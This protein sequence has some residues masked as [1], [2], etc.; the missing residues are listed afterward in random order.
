VQT[1]STPSVSYSSFNQGERLAN[2]ATS[3]EEG[4]NDRSFYWHYGLI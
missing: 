4:G 2:A 1:F 3:L